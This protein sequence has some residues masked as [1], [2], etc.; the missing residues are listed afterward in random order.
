MPT[1][2]VIAL[3]VALLTFSAAI[4]LGDG[5]ASIGTEL[6]AAVLALTALVLLA[7]ST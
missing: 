6:V 3:N 5:A 2:L 4:K 7:G 1:L